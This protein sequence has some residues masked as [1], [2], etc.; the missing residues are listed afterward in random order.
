MTT[1]PE[2]EVFSVD[3]CGEC[4]QRK[5]VLGEP[6]RRKRCRR[7]LLAVLGGE[8][9]GVETLRAIYNSFDTAAARLGAEL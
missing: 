6:G 7:C 5:T 3:T 9:V 8:M 1:V 4:G 2:T